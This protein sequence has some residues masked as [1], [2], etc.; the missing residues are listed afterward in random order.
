[1]HTVD[2]G[3]LPDHGEAI[4]DLLCER[5]LLDANLTFA[6][7]GSDCYEVHISDGVLLEV[8]GKNGIPTVKGFLA[9]WF[10]ALSCVMHAARHFFCSPQS[11]AS[12][13][14]DTASRLEACKASGALPTC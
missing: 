3:Y 2:G 5:G 13:T 14:S 1:M 8:K 7:I 9:G 4:T 10:A 6:P 11:D 12:N